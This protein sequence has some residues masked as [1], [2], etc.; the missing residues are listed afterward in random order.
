MLIPTYCWLVDFEFHQPAGGVPRPILMVARNFHSGETVR[1]WLWDEPTDRPPIPLGE[2][3]LYVAYLASAELSC[4][5]ALGWDQPRHVLDLYAEFSLATSGQK[6][7][8]GRGLLGALTYHGLRGIQAAEKEDLRALAIRG[9][10]YTPEEREALFAYCESDV[11]ALADLLPKMW[12]TLDFPRALIRG[13]YMKAVASVERVGVPL[14][15]DDLALL[16]SQWDDIQRKLVDR[17][18]GNFGVYEGLSFREKRFR[19]YCAGRGILWPQLES[20]SLSLAE[21]TFKRMAR[22]HP[23]IQP[24]HELRK[25]LGKMRLSD[26]AVGADG[27]NRY[28]TGVFRSKTGRNQPSSSKSIFGPSKWVRHL[29]KPGEGEALAY[30]DFSQQ[31]FGIGAALSRDASMQ[32][33]YLTGDP[34]LEFAKLAGAV[35]SHGT[36][37][38]HANE[39]AI[40]KVAALAILMGMGSE[41]LGFQTK[42]C[43]ATG[44]MLLRQHKE[45][46][47]Q[48]WKWSDAQV[49]RAQLGEALSTVFGWRL[50]SANERSTTYR[51]FKLQ[52]NGADI[53]RLAAIAI[54]ERGIRLCAMI[55][56]AVLIEAPIEQIDEVVEETRRQMAA[57][58]RAVLGGFEIGTDVEIVRYPDRFS[59][60]KGKELWE[61][62]SSLAGL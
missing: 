25:T 10:P 48:Y 38:S 46:F 29:I 36:K 16:Q 13:R 32:R 19:S 26:L 23:E 58:S 51:N 17:I 53:L 49:D 18:D 52:A 5:L 14:A 39:R 35:P 59:D 8:G 2:D 21:E 6:L 33:A 47:S 11:L 28:M 40:Y 37:E 4:H 34:Y 55:H 62:V 30:I 15:K 27:R 9:G 57:A 24:L 12:P 50:H 43:E 54:T 1:L 42:T 3:T 7:P 41:Q 45:V 22:L 31:E 44:R 56:D 61:T 20:G 60:A